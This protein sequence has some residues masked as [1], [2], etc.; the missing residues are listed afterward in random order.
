MIHESQPCGLGCVSQQ[1]RRWTGDRLSQQ[2]YKNLSNN[3][4][5][6]KNS[7]KKL[8]SERKNSREAAS[9]TREEFK[10]RASRTLPHPVARKSE[11]SEA[12]ETPQKSYGPSFVAAPM[13][14]AGKSPELSASLILVAAFLVGLHIEFWTNAVVL[15]LCGPRPSGSITCP[16]SCHCRAPDCR[17]S[18]VILESKWSLP[19]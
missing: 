6:W 12:I 19:E 10:T 4:K 13:S 1:G 9:R 17:S 8:K 7:K 5:H 11:R 18:E 2:S 14:H 16:S 15:C 3:K